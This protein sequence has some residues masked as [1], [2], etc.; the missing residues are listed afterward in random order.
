MKSAMT[1]T[2]HWHGMGILV[3]ASLW[4][5]S[6]GGGG[7]GGNDGGGDDEP[8]PP[9]AV[10]VAISPASA[11]LQPG[12]TQ[13]FAATVS[14]ATDTSVTWSVNGIDGGDATVG[15][16]SE[17]GLYTAPDVV[18]AP[19]TVTV[20]ATSQEDS[21][22]SASAAI[23]I[24]D[25]G[26]GANNAL[27][28][29]RYAFVF[30][31]SETEAGVFVAGGTFVADGAG[32]IRNGRED[33]NFAGGIF[34]RQGFDGVYAIGD[35]RRGV[36]I[37][38]NTADADC[39]CAPTQFTFMFNV[40]SNR[41]AHFIE[42]DDVGAGRGTIE[43]QDATAFSLQAL[44][45]PFVFLVDGLDFET[46][47]SIAGRFTSTLGSLS[48]AIADFNNS[49]A[50]S[51]AQ[52]IGGELTL[53]ENG[54]GEATLTTPLGD[55][56]FAYYVVSSDR[57]L[58]VGMDFFPVMSGTALRQKTPP[59]SGA[60]LFGRY[61][62]GMT[63]TTHPRPQKVIRA[64]AGYFDADG[65]GEIS[66]GVIDRNS[67]WSVLDG[68]ALSGSYDVEA[69]GRG[70][71]V[72][73][74]ED[75]PQNF[76][77]SLASDDVG[78]VLQVDESDSDVNNVASG[79]LQRQETTI[80]SDASFEGGYGL[81]LTGS[82]DSTDPINISGSLQADGAGVATTVQDIYTGSMT[83]DQAVDGSYAIPAT[84]RGTVT[85]PTDNLNLY[86]LTDT[87]ALLI[88]TDPE[89]ILFGTA[90]KQE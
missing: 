84:G 26:P 20:A 6:C 90:L 61:V 4:M 69:S 85:F 36:M 10:Q 18:P 50:V 76:V 32:Q 14:N 75:G 16:I 31:G 78:F 68:S 59:F 35:D 24:V 11:L 74:T 73:D 17:D 40:V 21:S 60:S 27:L 34:E 77:F 88:G 3:A 8:P 33:G 47:L 37:I 41:L 25:I 63:A 53:G 7:G 12:D 55:L 58:W 86:L 89:E 23:T 71:A 29:G 79:R 65:V 2:R 83:P 80:F 5:A 62:F 9:P 52:E 38:A 67:A 66:G 15:A 42:F 28:K 51:T 81:A 48:Q 87:E 1:V 43:K 56:H 64:D 39:G 49:E 82:S 19:D 30:V 13:A 46:R 44:D 54:R 72:L 22:K 45:G 70:T 57:L